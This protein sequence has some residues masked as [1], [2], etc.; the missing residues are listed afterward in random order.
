MKRVSK[1]WW[2]LLFPMATTLFPAYLGH[3]VCNE[4]VWI[5]LAYCSTASTFGIILPLLLI[6]YSAALQGLPIAGYSLLVIAV[7]LS[8]RNLDQKVMINHPSTGLIAGALAMAALALM[9][10]MVAASGMGDGWPTYSIYDLAFG[11]LAV[12]LWSWFFS[13]DRGDALEL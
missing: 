3:P 2:L 1:K 13:P 10:W 8:A 9:R 6:A 7:W 5:A 12:P 11:A 4:S